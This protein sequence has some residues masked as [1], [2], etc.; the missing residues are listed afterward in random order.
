MPEESDQEAGGNFVDRLRA[1]AAAKARDD[2]L[3]DPLSE[4]HKRDFFIDQKIS[5]TA[6]AVET[7]ANE[8]AQLKAAVA[9]VQRKIEPQP[10][11]ILY[12]V[13]LLV[14]VVAIGLLVWTGWANKPDVSID[15]NVGEIIG[16]LL[17]GIATMIAGLAYARRQGTVR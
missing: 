10:G 7:V 13:F 17:V 14:V 6:A 3:A 12:A 4:L 15:F 16:G 1:Q 2:F 8:I 5:K 11:H 9:D